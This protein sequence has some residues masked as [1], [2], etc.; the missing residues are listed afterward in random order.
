[1]RKLD[2]RW[3]FLA[4]NIIR[5]PIHRSGSI[6]SNQGNDLIDIRDRHLPAETSHAIGFELK[7]SNRPGF[8]EEFKSGF[9]FEGSFRYP[10]FLESFFSAD[11]AFRFR[12][13]GQ[14]F[15]TQKVHF[16]KTQLFHRILGIL[17]CEDSILRSQWHQ[18][19]QRTVGNDNAS[20][21]STHI[22]H[23]SLDHPAGIDD[24]FC[25][26]I[27]FVFFLKFRTFLNRIIQ[28]NVKIIRHHFGQFIGFGVR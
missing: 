14:G 4:L 21:M 22:P 8:I 26:R 18:F 20:R 6:K 27:I 28:G 12:N 3:I 13:H 5:N 24:L 17:S 11:M 25:N 9:V 15:E 10:E 1:M 23:H 16:Q 7:D 2:S 19:F